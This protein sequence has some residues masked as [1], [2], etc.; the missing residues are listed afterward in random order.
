MC[1][2]EAQLALS[3]FSIVAGMQQKNQQADMH[4]ANNERAA[5]EF[6]RGLLQD[7]VYLKGQRIAAVENKVRAEAD[8]KRERSAEIGEGLV[9]NWANPHAIMRDI[10]TSKSY[11]YTDIQADYETDMRALGREQD[12]SYGAYKRK[13]NSLYPEQ[14]A[15]MLDLG[16]GIGQASTDYFSNPNRLLFTDTPGGGLP[17]NANT[18]AFNVKST[19]MSW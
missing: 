7:D 1:T 18:A 10:G 4:N 19:N 6:D 3:A 5:R 8:L 15:S 11:D 17:G 16:L 12:E 2:P 13:Y 9:S 14:G